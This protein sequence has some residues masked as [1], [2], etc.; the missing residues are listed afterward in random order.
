MLPAGSVIPYFQF[1]SWR[2]NF[3]SLIKFSALNFGYIFTIILILAGCSFEKVTVIKK[4]PIEGLG[5]YEI[6]IREA[7]GPEVIVRKVKE[8]EELPVPS[9]DSGEEARNLPSQEEKT[10]IPLETTQAPL[11]LRRQRVKLRRN[12][13]LLLESLGNKPIP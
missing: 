5:G 9:D 2:S 11:D 12:R 10:E 3:C 6:V 4:R 1:L 7:K 13:Y 8:P